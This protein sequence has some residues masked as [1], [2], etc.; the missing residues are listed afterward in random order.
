M[1][2][3]QDAWVEVFPP[4]VVAP[5]ATRLA[6]LG[7]D[8]DAL[9]ALSVLLASPETS[10]RFR[11]APIEEP[12]GLRQYVPGTRLFFLRARADDLA[13]DA[14]IAAS[15]YATTGSASL[16]TAV[17]IFRR[18]VQTF[19]LLSLDEMDVVLVMRALCGTRD[20]EFTTITAEDLAAAYAGTDMDLD[21]QTTALVQKGALRRAQG[22]WVLVP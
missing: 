7:F 18:S 20:R 8:V 10:G 16:T 5:C 2:S 22:G 3:G 13:W 1:S 6:R 11:V 14:A 15:V 19:R 21:A 4:A 17:S 9:D 12:E